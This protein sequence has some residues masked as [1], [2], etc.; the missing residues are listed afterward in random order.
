MA[1]KYD[2]INNRTFLIVILV[3]TIIIYVIFFIWLIV[4]SASVQTLMDINNL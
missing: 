3:L 1:I 2:F 4:M